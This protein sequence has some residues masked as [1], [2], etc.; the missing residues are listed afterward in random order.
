MLV[1]R[2]L[3]F[4]EIT[5]QPHDDKM[6]LKS[7]LMRNIPILKFFSIKKINVDKQPKR[8]SRV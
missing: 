2:D 8:P 5:E 6:F 1:L 3:T 7:K 4:D